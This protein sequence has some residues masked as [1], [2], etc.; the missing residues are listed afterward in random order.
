MEKNIALK[1][2]DHYI[3]HG[4][5]N[6]PNNDYLPVLVYKKAFNAKNDKLAAIIE[7][8]FKNNNWTNN[9]RN[10]IL[11][12]HHYHSKTHEALGVATGN[13]KVQ[14]GGPN[15]IVLDVEAGDVLILPAGIAHSNLRCSADFEV[16]GGYPAGMDY[17]MNYGIEGERP[18]VDENIQKVPLPE[19]DP[20]Y[21]F[22]GA[23]ITFWTMQ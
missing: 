3:L 18:A 17:D 14:L 22:E 4:D 6:F 15:G 16:V 7:E 10:G 2:P 19:T 21:G 12:K 1:K 13:C 23:L 20:V 11:E 5:N 8:T 9:W